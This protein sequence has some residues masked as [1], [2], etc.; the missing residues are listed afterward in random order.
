MKFALIFIIAALAVP[1]ALAIDHIG[2]YYHYPVGHPADYGSAGWYGHG[3]GT[4]AP[5]G[6]A[7]CGCGPCAR[8]TPLYD[9]QPS[10]VR[11]WT[12]NPYAGLS[13]GRWRGY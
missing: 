12:S 3:Y 10:T 9:R 8:F 11:A 5:Y 2:G 7:G 6:G 13:L 1:G 4:S